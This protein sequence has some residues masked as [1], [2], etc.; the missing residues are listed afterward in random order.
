MLT[1]FT[2][3]SFEVVFAAGQLSSIA[4]EHSPQHEIRAKAG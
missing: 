2:T 4:V 3:I 1:S